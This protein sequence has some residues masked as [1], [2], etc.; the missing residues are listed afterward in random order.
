MKNKRNR[1]KYEYKNREPKEFLK[2]FYRSLKARTIVNT[3]RRL[4]K[5]LGKNRY[6]KIL[7]K[8]RCFQIDE[9]DFIEIRKVD[10]QEI[11]YISPTYEGQRWYSTGKIKKGN[12]DRNL[13]KY[14][15]LP[16]HQAAIK[17][18]KN[19]KK[20]EE[21]EE[22]Q[23][24]YE[25]GIKWP[26]N[27]VERDL[28]KTETLYNEIKEK[29]YLSQAEIENKDLNKAINEF[30]RDALNE[31]CVDLDRNGKPLFVDGRHRLSIAKIL[32][33]DQIPVR[34][35]VRHQEYYKK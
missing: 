2:W 6:L 27:K 26:T 31:V 17:R 34:I 35:V 28:E 14:E 10:P 11:E 15:N 23:K 33:L 32:E 19:G 24:A 13:E 29:G 22:V 1:L 18:F 16:F 5:I 9:E 12:W 3:H 30:N 21:I 20:W 7:K 8:I 4:S 25:G